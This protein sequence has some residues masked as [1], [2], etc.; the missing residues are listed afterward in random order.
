[1]PEHSAKDNNK[2][3]KLNLAE[4]VALSYLRRESAV[5]GRLKIAR[6]RERERDFLSWNFVSIVPKESTGKLPRCT[7]AVW[8]LKLRNSN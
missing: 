2:I 8:S 6:K 7:S 4:D 3:L 5:L 1:M